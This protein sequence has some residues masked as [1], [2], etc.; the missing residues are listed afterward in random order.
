MPVEPRKAHRVT[1]E[2]A[3]L[4]LDPQGNILDCMGRYTSKEL[5]HMFSDSK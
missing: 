3:G 2:T 5:K 4:M 1:P